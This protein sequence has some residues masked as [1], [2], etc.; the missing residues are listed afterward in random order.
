[1]KVLLLAFECNPNWPSLPVVGYKYALALSEKVEVCLVTQ[2]LN[3][4]N[5]EKAGT[6]K[7]TVDYIDI[8]YISEPLDRFG[9]WLRG[10]VNLGWTTQVALTYPTYVTF[11]KAVWHRYR[12][13]IKSGE[14]A[15]IHRITPM[16]PTL[17]SPLAKLSPIPFVLGPLN[18]GLDWPPQFKS[19]GSREREWLKKVRKIYKIFPY[20]KS[21][22][23]RSAAIMAS[24]DHTLRDIPAK[25]DDKTIDFPEVGFDPSLFQERQGGG[26]ER[27]KVVFASRLV[28]LKLPEVILAA[29]AQS[30]LLKGH[31]LIFVGDGPEKPKL[32]A[33]VRRLGLSNVTF[34]GWLSQKEVG[35]I[36]SQSDIFV[37]PSIKDLG[38]GALVEA[39]ATGLTPVAIDYGAS[40]TLVAE[41]R[42]IKVPLGSREQL[43]HDFR[44]SLESLVSDPERLKQLGRAAQAYVMQRM[45]W[46]IKAQKT[47]EIYQWVL[48]GRPQPKPLFW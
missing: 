41:D 39:M 33:E 3:R 42:G 18:G 14:F 46:D 8:D 34:K 37:F 24:F 40:S 1:M 16:T 32:E 29:F 23:A 36:L 12:E 28:P 30:E 15:L 7:M 13:R 20:A 31:D 48:K 35:A 4:E 25:Y 9:K 44:L 27:K 21:T 38:A 11:E 2:K 5:I 43:A 19:M 10:D 26:G 45:P 17:P 22:L 47:L 6:G